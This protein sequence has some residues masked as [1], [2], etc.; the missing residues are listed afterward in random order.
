MTDSII[1]CLAKLSFIIPAQYILQAM[2]CAVVSDY[3]MH[4]FQHQN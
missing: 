1:N 3:I 2:F 4:Q